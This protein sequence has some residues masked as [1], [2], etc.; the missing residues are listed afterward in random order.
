MKVS[1]RKCKQRSVDNDGGDFGNQIKSRD[2]SSDRNITE[3]LIIKRGS[4][5][6]F[7]KD[8]I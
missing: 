8:A 1:E 7:E 2:H 5:Y 4:I 3:T 6:D